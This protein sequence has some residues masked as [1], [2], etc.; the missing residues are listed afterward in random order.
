MD[1]QSDPRFGFRALTVKQPWASEIAS[2]TKRIE[3]RSWA[4][5]YRGDL[6]ITASSSPR[7][8]GPAGCA[9]CIVRLVDV[10]EGDDE[11]EWYLAAPRAVRNVPTLGK[12]QLWKPDAALLGKLGLRVR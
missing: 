9:I 3:Y 2:G 10:R 12:L 7:S 6:L 4:T 8:Q 5:D 1:V 11:M